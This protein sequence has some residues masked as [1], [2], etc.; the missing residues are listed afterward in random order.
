VLRMDRD[1]ALRIDSMIMGPL[2]TLDGIAH[3]KKNN[4][5]EHDYSEL[6]RPIG[7][8]MGELIEISESLHCRFPDIVPKELI[9]PKR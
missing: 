3:Y 2:G 6:V 7:R 5:S 9:P 1:V 4:L 8:A